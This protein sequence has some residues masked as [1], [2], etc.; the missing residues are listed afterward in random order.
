MQLIFF[1]SYLCED[2]YL[3]PI[4]RLEINA[5]FVLAVDFHRSRD[6]VMARSRDRR[7]LRARHLF[8]ALAPLKTFVWKTGILHH[9]TSYYIILHHITIILHHITSYYIILHHIT[10]YYNHI[11]SYHIILQSYCRRPNGLPRSERIK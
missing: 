9:I 4:R 3:K 10:S 5:G 7:E 2:L 1:F 11:T 8:D 6:D